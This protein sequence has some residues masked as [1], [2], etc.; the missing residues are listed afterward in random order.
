MQNRR[1]SIF[2]PVK[3]NAKT[4]VTLFLFPSKSMQN[5]RYSISVP[6][7]ENAKTGVTPAKL[8]KKW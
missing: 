7:K 4:G 5:R 6:V 1:Y 3:V 2:V 8:Q